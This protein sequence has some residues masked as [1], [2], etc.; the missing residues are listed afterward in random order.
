MM[1]LLKNHTDI[2]VHHIDVDIYIM[3]VSIKLIIFN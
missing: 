3:N 1:Q 2:L